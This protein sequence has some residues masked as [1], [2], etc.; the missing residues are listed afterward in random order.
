MIERHSIEARNVVGHSDIAPMRKVDPGELFNW[1]TLA[2]E[3]VGLWPEIKKIRKP[4]NPVITPGEE[5]LNVA[6]VQRMLSDYGYHI[7]VDGFYGPKTET[8][9][10]TFKRHFVQEHVNVVWDR[11]ADEKMRKLL[12]IVDKL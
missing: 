8:I 3:G 11:E 1:Q 5:S 7:R 4:H 12:E 9:I 2:A 6:D 10:K